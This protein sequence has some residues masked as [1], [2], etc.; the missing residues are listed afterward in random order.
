MF[1]YSH[2]TFNNL[3]FRATLLCIASVVINS[4]I[5]PQDQDSLPL[6]Q[7]SLPLI[8]TSAVNSISGGS[9]VAGGNVIS[10]GTG[11]L[12]ARGVVWGTTTNPTTNLSTKTN[13]G[14]TIGQFS[15]NITGLLPNT[16]YYFRAYAT[17]SIGTSYGQTLNFTTTNS[18]STS[19][20]VLVAGN[21]CGAGFV[22]RDGVQ[23][24][25]DDPSSCIN[26]CS[27][28]GISINGSDEYLVGYSGNYARV[29]KNGIKSTL[30]SN[31]P[32]SV[33]YSIAINGNDIYIAGEEF[34]DVSSSTLNPFDA[35]GGV[36]AKVWKNGIA[37]NLPLSQGS[38]HGGAKSIFTNGSDIYVAGY[39]I[40]ANGDIIAKYW[41]NG[42]GYNLVSGSSGT[43]VVR[44]SMATSI[45]VQNADIYVGGY[46]Q[47]GN[48]VV[49][50]IWKN[51]T[52]TSLVNTSGD[53][54]IRSV[55]VSGTNVYAVGTN[56]GC[57]AVGG[58]TSKVATIWTNGSPR[59]LS[60]CNST[61][62]EA[63]SI[64][65]K[66]SDVYVG[67]KYI[68]SCNSNCYFKYIVWKNGA[69][70]L[71]SSSIGNVYTG[72]NALFVK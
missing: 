54:I 15:S 52:P 37:T 39:E 64:F 40:R 5:K 17:S 49:G 13:D 28:T 60:D 26:N 22:L 25:Y 24:K 57:S 70:Y 29:W 16:V 36:S 7:D 65:V 33:A 55:F 42:V 59:Y 31:F 69:Q 38:I 9:A 45:F 56:Y 20:S 19:T 51:S 72:V 21:I 48:N 3:F 30:S 63:M 6:I 44:F 43:P 14:S 1:K 46:E 62:A 58:G 10:A 68:S 67:G 66:G 34:Q 4:C 23:T 27:I 35:L 8:S 11:V 61:D 50:K 47:V 18:T 32:V 53:A 41:K 12:T 71:T 2:K